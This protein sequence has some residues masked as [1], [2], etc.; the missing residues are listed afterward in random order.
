MPVP[1]AEAFAKNPASVRSVVVEKTM[2]PHCNLNNHFEHVPRISLKK[3]LQ[4][5]V[6]RSARQNRR[7]KRAGVRRGIPTY[8]F[9]WPER[10]RREPRRRHVAKN[11][12]IF[13]AHVF[14]SSLAAAMATVSL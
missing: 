5:R 14:S 12:R 3:Q 8:R 13:R 6:L 9:R 1:H 7:R 10:P 4:L 11:R 2:Q